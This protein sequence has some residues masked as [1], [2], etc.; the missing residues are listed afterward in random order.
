MLNASSIDNADIRAITMMYD[1]QVDESQSRPVREAYTQLKGPMERNGVYGYPWRGMLPHATHV[2]KKCHK[3]LTS[4]LTKLA[5]AE[6]TSAH[7][8]DAPSLKGKPTDSF[9]NFIYNEI[10]GRSIMRAYVRT[11]KSWFP[12]IRSRAT[13]TRYTYK[14]PFQYIMELNH[15]IARLNEHG[16]H[17]LYKGANNRRSCRT[18]YA[19]SSLI[20]L[21]TSTHLTNVRNGQASMQFRTHIEHIHESNNAIPTSYVRHA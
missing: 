12:I 17:T 1:L 8:L 18:K 11:P 4:K 19:H 7:H 2:C 5:A 16:I 21:R 3:A 15:E 6:E 20:V 9:E 10:A 13:N 14:D